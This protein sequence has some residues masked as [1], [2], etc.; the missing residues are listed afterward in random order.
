MDKRMS[1]R[2]L[3]LDTSVYNRPFDDVS[4]PRIWFEALAFAAILQMRESGS[5]ELVNSDVLEY[6][7]SRNPFLDR[8][9][10]VNSYLSLAGIYQEVDDSIR[11]RAQGLESQ[12]LGSV[13]ALHLACAEE[14]KAEY[15][16]TCDDQIIKRYRGKGLK[17]MNPVNFVINEVIDDDKDQDGQ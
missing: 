12:G 15:F 10:W 16:I 13:D 9:T 8:K 17:A 1:P 11:I 2:R 14:S 5:V 6:E 3:Y 4:Q 7:N